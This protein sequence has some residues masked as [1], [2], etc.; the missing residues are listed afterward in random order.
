MPD[1][2]DQTAAE[3][4]PTLQDLLRSM[5]EGLYVVDRAGNC[6]LAN[7][8]CVAM[9]GY[10]SAGDL[11][12]HNMHG[13]IHHTRPDGTPYPVERCHIYRAFLD[14]TLVHVTDEV[15]WR[16]DGS[17]LEVEYWSHPIRRGGQVI[18]SVLTFLD[19]GERKRLEEANAQMRAT[20]QREFQERG[21][22]LDSTRD[23]LETALAC[24]NI[25]LW[26]WN[27][28][29][30]EVFFSPTYK[31][32]LGYPETVDW[33]DFEAWRSR[34][35]P[36]DLPE[37]L[38]A[39]DDYMSKRRPDYKV[40]FRMRHRD[41]SDRWFQA[42]GRGSFERDGS[43]SRMLGVHV[44]VT[45]RLD[46]ERELARLNEQAARLNAALAD[47]NT[48]LQQ[49][50]YVA[51][52]DLKAP[53]RGIASFANL[54]QAEYGDRLDGSGRDY[55]ERM[56]ASVKRLQRMIDDLLA[57]SRVESRF[58]GFR[59]V[60]LREVVEDVLTLLGPAVRDCDAEV[61]VGDLPAVRGDRAQLSQLMN[62]L[63]GNA[64][65]YGG[66]EPRIRVAMAED[67]G[68]AGG[69]V[70]VVVEDNGIGVDPEH[71]ERIFEVFRR[72]HTE[73]EYPGTGIGLAVCRRIVQRHGGEIWVEPNPAGGSRFLVRLPA[74]GGAAEP[75]GAADTGL[76]PPLRGSEGGDRP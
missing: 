50:A 39:I 45:E 33:N 1:G 22:A 23:Q 3:S 52:H 25:G 61:L 38:R 44:D 58:E 12:G 15:F 53:L 27:A 69:P 7:D 65:K 6:T 24:G 18:G 16:R 29:T 72:L 37:A 20:L 46:R 35:H 40:V 75:A 43:V 60:P 76:L 73:K 42:E 47:S 4:G 10:D 30:N 14:E 71:A 56:V 11:L 26:D 57:Y 2:D 62:N 49:F 66:E 13:L 70:T 41:G 51:S 54:I 8:A 59:D 36:D 9:L 21:F 17:P 68:D 5:A 19:V 31:K 34:V 63:I 74:A 64:L 32:Q 48:E 28:R 67:A 55:L